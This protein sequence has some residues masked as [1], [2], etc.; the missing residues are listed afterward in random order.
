LYHLVQVKDSYS[1]EPSLETISIVNEFPK[2]FPDVLPSIPLDKEI[3]FGVGLVS[4]TYMISI[5]TK[6]MTLIELKELKEKLNNQLN[7]GFIHPSMSP[8]GAF[9]LFVR[10]KDCSLRMCINYC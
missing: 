6:R 10:K 7:K 3:Y 8:W 1:D 5:P 2:L 4:D 9:V